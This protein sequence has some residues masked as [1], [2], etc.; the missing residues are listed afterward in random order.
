MNIIK[1]IVPAAIAAA[2]LTWATSGSRLDKGPAPRFPLGF[3]TSSL[4]G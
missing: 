2:F 1:L 4:V 3:P